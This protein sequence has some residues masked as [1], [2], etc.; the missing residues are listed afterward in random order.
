M[1]G[2]GMFPA[3]GNLNRALMHIHVQAFFFGLLC[4]FLGVELLGHRI[5]VSVAS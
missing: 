5:C 2:F 4:S 3:F 1:D